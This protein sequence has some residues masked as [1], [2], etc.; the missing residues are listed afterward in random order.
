VDKDFDIS[1][2][3]NKETGVEVSKKE[4]GTLV[5]ENPNLF[6]EREINE[7][8]NVVRY[9]YDPKNPNGNSELTT[10]ADTSVIGT[11]ANFKLTTIGGTKIELSKLKGK[12]VILRFELSAT[13]FHFKKQEIQELDKQINELGNK[14]TV[15][16]IIIFQCSESDVRKGFDL[17]DSNFEL[18]ANGQNFIDKY[19][20][21]RS[22]S[23]LLI[24][25][26]GNLIEEYYY[27]EDIVLK[28]HLSK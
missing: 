28:E 8:G 21:S 1:K 5:K 26:N 12:M 11:F 17:Q 6:L 24:D 10:E 2:V 9:L 27:S 13:D 18:V 19:G 16:A 7:A 15:K 20:I 4:F 23:T 14:N 3:Y 25:Q 22:P